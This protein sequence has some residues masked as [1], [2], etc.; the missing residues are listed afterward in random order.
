MTTYTES[1]AYSDGTPIASPWDTYGGTPV[2]RSGGIQSDSGFM[3]IIDS[4]SLTANQYAESTLGPAFPAAGSLNE[5]FSIFL[6]FNS[7]TVSGYF[8]L[9][10][11]GGSQ[12]NTLAGGST[13]ATLVSNAVGWAAGDLM[14]FSARG[15]VLTVYKNNAPVLT[16]TDSTYTAGTAGL[17]IG[18][19]TARLDNYRSC[20]VPP[21]SVYRHAIQ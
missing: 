13:I 1:W 4:R 18:N 5:G 17:V 12:I 2:I 10:L 3:F 14:G 16:T 8:C 19:Q 9:A 20:D 6:R 21:P 11:A 7:G 15:S